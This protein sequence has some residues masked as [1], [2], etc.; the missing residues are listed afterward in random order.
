MV[1]KYSFVC[2]KCG[3]EFMVEG[4]WYNQAVMH[5]YLDCKFALH[6]IIKHRKSITRKYLKNLFIDII[7]WIPLL[8]LQAIDIILEPLR[9]LL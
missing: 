4:H 2:N 9:R 6:I 3:K 5:H 8:V 7:A 1:T